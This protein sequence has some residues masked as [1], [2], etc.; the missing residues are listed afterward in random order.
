MNYYKIYNKD[1]DAWLRQEQ[2][3]FTDE[4][5]AGFWPE[6]AIINIEQ[7]DVQKPVYFSPSA[8]TLKLIEFG[9]YDFCGRWPERPELAQKHL[10]S[11]QNLEFRHLKA[12]YYYKE[13]LGNTT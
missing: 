10:F 11:C 8:T 1:V 12:T 5:H 7:S 9:V 4:E 2:S 6:P 13:T 3:G